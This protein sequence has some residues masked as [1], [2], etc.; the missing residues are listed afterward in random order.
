MKNLLHKL[1]PSNE[2]LEHYWWCANY[3]F[4]NYFYTFLFSL[5]K[6]GGNNIPKT[7]PVLLIAN[8]ESF[9]DPISVGLTSTRNLCYLARKTLFKNPWLSSYLKA[10]G[11][12]PVDLD[13]VAKEGIRAT[14]DLL[15]KNKVV[16]LFP[17]GT[18]SETGN[19]QNLQPG[20]FLLAKKSGAPILPVGIAGAYD[21]LPRT[22]LIPNFCPLFKE[23]KN[24]AMA[25]SIG[26]PV[27]PAQLEEMGREKALVFL[28][29]KILE[30]INKAN[31]LKRKN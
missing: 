2:T 18:R 27:T 17:E 30:E 13:G 3:I 25:V 9:L 20:I 26:K 19:V 5:R 14:L 1:L 16:L 23:G 4:W 28:K 31:A 21:A 29:E 24:G 12:F 15:Q 8:H 11:V 6:Q 7:G 22:T 10:V